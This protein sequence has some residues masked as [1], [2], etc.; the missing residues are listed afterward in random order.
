MSVI[1]PQLT[2]WGWLMHTCICKLTLIGSDNGL[3]LNRQQAI[4]WT[5]ARMLL[6][7]SVG[8]NLITEILIKI[9]KF[10]LK[11]MHLKMLSGKW[12]PSCLGL[13]ILNT[14]MMDH[15][16]ICHMGITLQEIIGLGVE[17]W[18]YYCKCQKYSMKCREHSSNHDICV[19][20]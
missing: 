14:A 5:N 20:N 7:G 18:I 1:N 8:T 12:Q 6:I 15:G 3:V 2:H 13:N 11:K 9:Y 19:L 16:V 4:I 17:Y 10:S